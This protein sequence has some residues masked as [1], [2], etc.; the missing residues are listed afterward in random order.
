MYH[1]IRFIGLGL[2]LSDTPLDCLESSFIRLRRGVSA[3]THHKEG[4]TYRDVIFI[5]NEVHF[6]LRAEPSNAVGIG[7]NECISNGQYSKNSHRLTLCVSSLTISALSFV[8]NHKSAS[9]RKKAHTR[10]KLTISSITALPL[11]LVALA[12]TRFL[13]HCATWYK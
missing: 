2:D 13:E 6:D 9:P 1:V 10:S 12:A 7:L 5:T 4:F 3:T 11:G 8:Y